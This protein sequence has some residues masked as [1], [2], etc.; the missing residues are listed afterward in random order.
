[1]AK[2]EHT[3]NMNALCICGT[4]R[5]QKQQQHSAPLP[6]IV[7]AE[8][9][10]KWYQT[11]VFS[12]FQIFGI[13]TACLCTSDTDLWL[14]KRETSVLSYI[15]NALFLGKSS[16]LKGP[17]GDLSFATAHNAAFLWWVELHCQHWLCGTLKTTSIRII[18][19][20]AQSTGGW[21]KC[22]DGTLEVS[23]VVPQL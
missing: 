5:S 2:T 21:C 22:Q 13:P 11:H 12:K 17:E 6:C 18:T 3:E 9:Q 4:T 14:Y 16:P 8:A 23:L 20:R 10:H 15:I 1:M 19:N 7:F